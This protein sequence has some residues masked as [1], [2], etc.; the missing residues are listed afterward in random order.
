METGHRKTQDS[1]MIKKILSSGQTGAARAALDV[2]IRLGIPYGGW[3]REGRTTE[4]GP[5]SAEYQLGE[6]PVSTFADCKELNILESDGTL[7]LSH[8]G[9]SG[10]AALTQKIA[11]RKDRPVLHVDLNEMRPLVAASVI[12]DWVIAHDVNILNVAGPPAS[13][14]P[15]IYTHTMKTLE[16]AYRIGVVKS[17]IHDSLKAGRSMAETVVDVIIPILSLRGKAA[18][19]NMDEADAKQLANAFLPY[20]KSKTG[21]GIDDK[22]YSDIMKQLLRRLQETHKLRVVK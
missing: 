21:T 10:E 19:G 15:K 2:A 13:K 12:N 7:L 17:S 6:I 18:L 11:Q 9:L 1:A 14:D 20:I 8:G 3:I 4:S 5:L 22:E 16:A